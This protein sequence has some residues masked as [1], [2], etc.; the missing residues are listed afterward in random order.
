[1][2]VII[3]HGKYLSVYNNLINVSVKTGDKIDTKQDIGEVFRAPG[4]EGTSTMKFMIFEEKYLNPE[5][6]LAK[7]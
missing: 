2:T 3:R 6:W 1:M 5:D 4:E 7:I